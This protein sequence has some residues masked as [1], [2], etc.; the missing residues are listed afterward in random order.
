MDIGTAKPTA[1]QRDAVRHHMIDIKK[2]WEA[3]SAGEYVRMVDGLIR[4]FSYRGMVPLIVGGTGLYVR[5]L[6]RGLF[7]G[8]TA[9]KSFRERLLREENEKEEGSLH[10]K[11]LKVDPEAAERIHPKDLRR[12]V[13]ALEVYYKEG[14]PITYLQDWDERG[15]RY[16][17]IKIC[18]IRDR[19]ELYR[20]IEQRVDSMIKDGLEDEVKRL[21]EMGCNETMTS[22]Q[23]LGYRHFLR[24][25]RGDYP[26]DEAIRLFKRDTKRYA[27]RQFT[28]FRKE[29]GI[30]WVDITGIEDPEEIVKRIIPMIKDYQYASEKSISYC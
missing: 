7:K 11:L 24:Y 13:R 9:D 4:D 3:F 14:R 18:L 30:E 27:K 28:W 10:K 23:A 17:F 12:I 2:P 15:L 25:F 29:E 8:A 16:N 6:I 20:R 21:I 19:R 1:E 22:M 26:K 5:A